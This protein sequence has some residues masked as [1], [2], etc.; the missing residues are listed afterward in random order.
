MIRVKVARK[1]PIAQD[2]CSIELVSLDGSPLPAFSAGAHID[3]DTGS[4][5]TRQYSL[6]NNPEDRHRYVIGVLRDPNSR[7]GSVAMHGLTDGRTIEISEPRNH[8]PLVP[9]AKHTILLAGGIG[10]TPLL[11]MAERLLREHA[12]FELHYCA[13]SIER[14]AFRDRLSAPD[15]GPSVTVHLD[16]GPADQRFDAV[17]FFAGNSGS[18]GHHLYVCGPGGFIDGVLEAA[19]SAGFSA[20]QLHR[21]YFASAPASG[22]GSDRAFRVRVVS[23]GEEFEVGAAQT[24]IEAL[25]AHGIEVPVSCEQ[26]VCG[27]CLTR[28]LDGI[29][30]HRDVYLTDS[31]HAKHDQFLPCCSRAKTELLVLDL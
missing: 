29:P 6:C 14:V 20:D 19:R 18:D 22:G 9:A 17:R 1:L 4:G 30:D 8:F 24:V 13:R 21:E 2:I 16:D 25:A 15:L 7:G 23:S 5:F 27:T 10:I 31:E 28:V 26:G 11:C 3:V 12:S